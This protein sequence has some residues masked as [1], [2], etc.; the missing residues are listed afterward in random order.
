MKVEAARIG[1]AMN[2][3]TGLRLFCAV[4]AAAILPLGPA[5]ATEDDTQF[6]VVGTIVGEPAED[7]TA[8]LEINPRFRG[9]TVGDDLL[10]TRATLDYRLSPAVA[11]GAGLLYAEFQGGNE[12]RTHQQVNIRAGQV[13]FRTRLEERFFAGAD[14]MELRLRQ[15][16]QATFPLGEGTAFVTSGE[17]Y[18]I[19]RSRRNDGDAKV[20]QWRAQFALQHSLGAGVTGAVGYLLILVP[21][22]GPNRVSHVPQIGLTVRL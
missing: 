19:L 1:P 16:V 21:R 22:D 14:R 3:T 9:A 20:D 17:M 13:Q 11:V 10:Q 7:L 12:T 6:W 8:A 4:L 5:R 18:S 2:R 15:R